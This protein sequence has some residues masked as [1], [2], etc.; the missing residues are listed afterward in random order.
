MDLGEPADGL[1]EFHIADGLRDRLKSC[2]G[3]R[4]EIFDGALLEAPSGFLRAI[5]QDVVPAE[6]HEEELI[7]FGDAVFLFG[8][9]RFGGA[10]GFVAI[11]SPNVDGFQ[12]GR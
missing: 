12:N 10:I 7:D 5:S 1:A 2:S 4:D 3:L 11:L 8:F 6:A 9:G